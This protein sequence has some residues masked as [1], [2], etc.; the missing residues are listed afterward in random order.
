MT[1]F[2]PIIGQFQDDDND[3]LLPPNPLL[4][5][6]RPLFSARCDRIL[7]Q[8][9]LKKTT[10]TRHTAYHPTGPFFAQIMPQNGTGLCVLKLSPASKLFAPFERKILNLTK[11]KTDETQKVAAFGSSSSRRSLKGNLA[12]DP[13]QGS[14]GRGPVQ[15]GTKHP[16]E[17][18]KSHNPAPWFGWLNFS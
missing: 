15:N 18:E 13:P 11:K 14:I 12:R 3:G 16:G 1:L 7:N 6:V 4:S 5:I 8:N 2:P 17:V 9:P 10:H